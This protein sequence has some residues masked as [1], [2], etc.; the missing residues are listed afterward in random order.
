MILTIRLFVFS[1]FA[2]A[3]TGNEIQSARYA[4]VAG[5]LMATIAV[6]DEDVVNFREKMRYVRM[7]ELCYAMLCYAML[8]MLCYAMLCYAMLFYVM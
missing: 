1:F 2:F 8:Y 3:G 4:S 5:N 6:V 7:S